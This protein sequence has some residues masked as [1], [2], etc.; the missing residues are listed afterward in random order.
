MVRR[1]LYLGRR[2]P[3]ALG[4][5]QRLLTLRPP[6]GGPLPSRPGS[7]PI[8]HKA[9][10]PELYAGVDKRRSTDVTRPVGGA[11]SCRRLFRIAGER[12][13]WRCRGSARARSVWATR[14]DEGRTREA[15]TA[16]RTGCWWR[17]S[18]ALE[19]GPWT[20]CTRPPEHRA[21]A[22]RHR[23]R[24]VELLP[25]AVWVCDADGL[26][27]PQ[28]QAS[29]IGADPP[30]TGKRRFAVAS[31]FRPDG[32]LL[33]RHRTPVAEVLRAAARCGGSGLI[34]KPDG[35]RVRALVYAEPIRNQAGEV[36]GAISC[37]GRDRAREHPRRGTRKQGGS[38]CGGRTEPASSRSS[39]GGRA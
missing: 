32:Q 17:G 24:I 1:G 22:P 2:S 20:R 13:G 16:D 4:C 33:P 34:E 14:R 23:R 8:F 25:V 19:V 18:R 6:G 11:G 39:P 36:T 12:G 7:A 26:I 29:S 30:A 9:D 3:G 10:G 37:F 35:A 21:R 27:V 15:D 38:P 31:A 28:P 5:V